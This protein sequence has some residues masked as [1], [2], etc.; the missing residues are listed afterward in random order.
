MGILFDT[1]NLFHAWFQVSNIPNIVITMNTNQLGLLL[2][3]K[4]CDVN[5]RGTHMASCMKRPHGCKPS[6]NSKWHKFLW[7]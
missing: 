4:K 2:L 3:V 7:I 5:M 1:E 6:I